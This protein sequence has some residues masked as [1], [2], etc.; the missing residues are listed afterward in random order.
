[1]AVL[2][3]AERRV[4]LQ[5]FVRRTFVEMGQRSDFDTNA[6]SDALAAAD[7]WIDANAG[8]YN[9][10]LPAAFRTNA[11]VQQK[12]LLFC[13]VALKRAGVI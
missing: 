10:A 12:T 4:A 8:S 6:L 3:D 7:G 5:H 11:T 2:S 13:Y 1:M 9:N